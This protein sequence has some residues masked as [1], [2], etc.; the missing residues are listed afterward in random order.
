MFSGGKDSTCMVHNLLENKL[1]ID[2]IVFADLHSEWP[3]MYPHIGQ[4]E[5]N[6]GRDI[7]IVEHPK[8]D[9][10]YWFYEREKQKGNTRVK[11]YGWCG[12]IRWGTACKREAI[13]K[14][15]L[16]IIKKGYEIVEYH[17]V[18][19]NEY[20]RTK[21]NKDG[22]TILYPLVDLKITD[23]DALKFCKSIGYTWGGLYEILDRVSC[24]CCENKNIKELWQMYTK[25]PDIWKR[26]EDLQSKTPFLYKGKG[27]Q[28]F[29]DKFAKRKETL[30]GIPTLI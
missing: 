19:F 28:Y 1:P 6:I 3:Q 20:Y 8:G 7:T 30:T 9:F 25:F 23:R 4:V 24:W 14:F 18:A 5:R 21:N 11:G 29:S 17:G 12:K 16:G 10:W 13:A 22:R 26:L 15:K 27:T 2:L